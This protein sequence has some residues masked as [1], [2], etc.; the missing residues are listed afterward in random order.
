MYNTQ[1]LRALLISEEYR[2]VNE[3]GQCFS[4]SNEIYKHMSIAMDGNPSNKHVQL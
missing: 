3:I 4:P 1:K 2:K